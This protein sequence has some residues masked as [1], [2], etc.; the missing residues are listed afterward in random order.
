MTISTSCWL[1]STS[2]VN[3]SVVIDM[4]QC[5]K[6]LNHD[7]MFSFKCVFNGVKC[8]ALVDALVGTL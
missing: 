8:R 1:T 3:C 5:Y 4:G 2:A 7:D 6:L